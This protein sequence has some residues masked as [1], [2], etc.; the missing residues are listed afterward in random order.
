[1]STAATTT[2]GVYSFATRT[3][4]AALVLLALVVTPAPLLP[5]ERAIELVQSALGG[6]PKLAYL[7]AAL[8]IHG[9]FYGSAGMLATFTLER[10]R[11]PRRQLLRIAV[12][13]WIVVALAIAVRSFKLGHL[14][15]AANAIVPVAAVIAGVGF[16]LGF[17]YHA[18]KT[19]LAAAALLAAAGL[20]V[21]ISAPSAALARA[22]E[23][24]L[25][26]LAAADTSQASGDARFAALVEA[27]FAPPRDNAD[28]VEHN[29]AALLALGIALGDERAARLVGITLDPKLMR[30]IA[31]LREGVTLN[32]RED[33][34]R[35]YTLSAALA[36]LRHPIA[37]DAA[38]LMKEEL[39]ALTHGSGFS[40]ADLAADRAGVRFAGAATRSE[41][42]AR[43][44]QARL[45]RG[46]SAGDFFPAVHDLPENLT[47]EQFRR[48]YGGVGAALYR[49]MVARIEARLDAL[50]GLETR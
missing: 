32:G 22:T 16:G 13:P 3:G 31:A 24:Q 17:R 43:A 19:A 5:P 40:F 6:T 20:W 23:V 14:P 2:A 42:S 45:A 8:G 26:R 49:R 7:V 37:A 36:V 33:W 46:F 4:A 35:H 28:P 41:A 38:G 30:S 27:A 44:L 11:S 12:M 47:T 34:A 29:R 15:M 25:R 9:L 21:W 48:D 1:M 10:A 39:D 50:P 18:W